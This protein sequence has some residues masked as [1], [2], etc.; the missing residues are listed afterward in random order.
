MCELLDS[1]VIGSWI[2]FWKIRC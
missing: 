2:K 1:T